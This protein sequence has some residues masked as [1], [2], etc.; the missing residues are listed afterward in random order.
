MTRIYLVIISFMLCQCQPREVSFDQLQT[1]LSDEDNGLVQ[2]ANVN[3]IKISVTYK[4]TDLLIYQETDQVAIDAAM[5]VTL[6]KKYSPYYY[7]VLSLSHNDNEVL[8]HVGGMNDYSRIV[9]TMSFRMPQ[10]VN[11]TTSNESTIPVADFMLN[12]TYGLSSATDVLFVFDKEKAKNNEWVQFNLN[13]L[14]LGIGNQR[15]RFSV[16]DIE[17]V[18]QLKFTTENSH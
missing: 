13:E 18:P 15:F 7:F 2:S 8:Q 1:F 5:L 14:G 16:R 12:R 4:P 10:Y 6:G 3:G 11:L 9:Q 17:K